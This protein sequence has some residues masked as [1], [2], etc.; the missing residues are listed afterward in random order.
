M[1]SKLAKTFFSATVVS[2]VS[3][4]LAYVLSAAAGETPRSTLTKYEDSVNNTHSVHEIK[5]TT[6]D[7]VTTVTIDADSRNLDVRTSERPDLEV[8]FE[9]DVVGDGPSLRMERKNG[10]LEIGLLPHKSKN[11]R[12]QVLHARHDANRIALTLPKAYRE[13]ITLRAQSGD[14][15][16]NDLKVR[17][18]KISTSSGDVQ[19]NNSQGLASIDSSSGDVTIQGFK[20][21]R[22]QVDTHSGDIDMDLPEAKQIQCTS[23]SGDVTIKLKPDAV[24]FNLQTHSGTVKNSFPSLPSAQ[25]TVVVNT[26]SGDISIAR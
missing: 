21:D 22:L 9:G 12:I 8:E 3:F 20:G 16:V 23:Q 11:W 4:A 5:S 18:L 15:E 13:A 24:R 1:K 14:V 2:G 19:L 26:T 6:L 25:N 17:A 7:N 10:D